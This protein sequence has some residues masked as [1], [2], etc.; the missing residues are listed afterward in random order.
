[1]R[2]AT[3]PRRWVGCSTVVSSG[4]TT[5]AT[6]ESVKPVTAICPGTPTPFSCSAF[7]SPSASSSLEANTA[8]GRSPASTS[9]AAS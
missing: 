4:V 5:P 3:M 8:S 1:M 9:R 7:I 2:A 6:G